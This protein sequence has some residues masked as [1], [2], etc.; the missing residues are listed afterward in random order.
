MLPGDLVLVQG[1]E[2]GGRGVVYAG[3]GRALADEQRT[4]V[5][6]AGTSTAGRVACRLGRGQRCTVGQ[7]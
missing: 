1:D 4:D 2:P 6:P 7:R 5:P 3:Y